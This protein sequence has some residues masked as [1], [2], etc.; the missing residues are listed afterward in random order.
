MTVFLWVKNFRA[1]SINI[2]KREHQKAIELLKKHR[3]KLDKLA[4]YLYD[5]K[6]IMGEV[7]MEI[8]KQA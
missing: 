2:I 8:L 5:K 6:A 4:G 7:F 1:K 3:N